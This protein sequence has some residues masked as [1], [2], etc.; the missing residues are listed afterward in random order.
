[1]TDR[2]PLTETLVEESSIDSPMVDSGLE[3]SQASTIDE[4]RDMNLLSSMF[5][6]VHGFEGMKQDATEI[7]QWAREKTGK[8]SG[9]ELLG[10]IK[11]T[12]KNMGTTELRKSLVTKLRLYSALDTRQS[13]LQK[14]KE[15]L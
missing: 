13:S 5:G 15:L 11:S 1:M 7:L 3:L 12:I 10:F 2:V 14:Q 6:F 9:P 4:M 8:F